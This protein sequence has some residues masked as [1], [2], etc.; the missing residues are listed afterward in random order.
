V[1]SEE[2]RT[3][4]YR[5]HRIL[6]PL[7]AMIYFSP[8]AEERYTA[9]GLRPGRMGY[10]AS[11]AAPMGSVSA[12]TVAAT[13]YNFNPELVAR[14]IP[15]AWTLAAPEQVLAARFEA[16]D[17]TLRRLLGDAV[18][19]PELAEAAAL[20]RTAADGCATSGRPLYA[21]HA[22]L[23]WPSEPHV[24]LWHAISLL[25]EHRGDGHIA[26]LVTND[27]GGL[28]ALI[29]HTATGA[30]FLPAAAKASRGWSDEQWDGAHA[31]LRAAGVLND[32]GGLTELGKQLR[33]RVED[34][35]N[36]SA[37]APWLHLGVEKASRLHELGR[38]LSRAA[39]AAGAFPPGVFTPRRD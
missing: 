1:D 16:V 14:H 11:R 22:E 7:H 17:V 36:A 25:R 9:A 13:F 2:A 20:A 31:Q 27:V 37:V 8:E 23:D 38:N 4:A 32:E 34:Q 28:A 26:A 6:E 33:E 39:V 3:L 30:G 12:G 29:T 35:T 19:S 21:A 15:R 18:S 5:C 24:V 10:F